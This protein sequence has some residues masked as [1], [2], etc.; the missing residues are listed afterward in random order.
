MAEAKEDEEV[1]KLEEQVGASESRL[2]EVLEQY[3]GDASR[4]KI[5]QAWAALSSM[6]RAAVHA[7]KIRVMTRKEKE[8]KKRMKKRSS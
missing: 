7:T 5:P 4:P 8:R 2:L 3:R 1:K 6:E